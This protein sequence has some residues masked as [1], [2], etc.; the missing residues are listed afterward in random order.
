[1]NPFPVRGF[2]TNRLSGVKSHLGACAAEQLAAIDLAFF[3]EP[4]YLLIIKAERFAKDKHDP[5]RQR[6]PLQQ[7]KHPI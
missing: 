5:F 1:M 7:N 3:N 6:Q 4:G 2:G